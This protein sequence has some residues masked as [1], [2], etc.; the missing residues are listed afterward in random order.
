MAFKHEKDRKYRS[1]YIEGFSDG[2]KLAVSVADE[3]C[4]NAS[5]AIDYGIFMDTLQARIDDIKRE[6]QCLVEKQS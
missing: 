2:V 5:G 3:V 6:L 1:R 4:H